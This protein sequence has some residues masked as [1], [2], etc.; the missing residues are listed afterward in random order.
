AS[1]DIVMH[2]VDYNESDSYLRAFWVG[3][4]N[5]LLVSVLG[6]IFS[7]I[8][9]F[10][11]GIARLSENWLVKKLSLLYIESIRNIPLLLQLFF[12][13]FSVLRSLPDVK[14]SF[15]WQNLIFL[16]NRGL[17][18]P[19]PYFSTEGQLHWSVPHLNFFNFEGGLVI[20]P[21]FIALL[22]A[23][24]I[25]TGS[26]IA[27]IVR[28]GILSVNSGQIEASKALGFSV[29][30]RL[31]LIIIPQAL[32]VIIPP[33]TSQLLNLTK[34]SSLAA[35]IAY[36]DLVLIFTGTVLLQTGQAVEVVLITMTVY[37][38][39]SLFISLIMNFYNKKIKWGER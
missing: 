13:Y 17:Y 5:T 33:L 7:T 32:R 4:T 21:E 15:S 24:S 30:Q 23:L 19:K 31:R 6:I 25:Y 9:G 38:C 39:I 34:N 12:W 36:P 22:L 14:Q 26:F 16:N 10:S 3:L 29:K 27:E 18:L 1:F 8:I 37:L 28:A 11:M 20:I 35:A 2:I